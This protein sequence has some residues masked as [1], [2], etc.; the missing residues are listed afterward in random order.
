[1]GLDWHDSGVVLSSRPLGERDAVVTLLTREH[2][3]H[4]GLV[5]G[6]A[7]RRMTPVLQAGN[8]VAVA[9]RARLSDHL[10]SFTLELL[11]PR[12][13]AVLD[14]A[15]RLAALTAIC[16]LVEQCLPEREPH[17]RLFDGLAVVFDTIEAD[18]PW[19]PLM[20]RFEVELLAELGFGLDLANCAVTGSPDD[21]THVSPRTG[22]AVSAR[23]A[24]PYGDRLLRLPRFLLG[25]QA[26][27]DSLEEV[28]DGFALT[29]H[30]IERHILGP[31]GRGL[32]PARARLLN[33]L[34]G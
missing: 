24:E 4:P 16:A 3:R 31:Q 26:G 15:R 6:G 30:F 22:R 25:A 23:A 20:V 10:G 32:P 14:S 8:D 34:L 1:M 28:A 12:A 33:L 27:S 18:G 11:R 21:L 17:A 5:R 19:A 7:G 9:W 2:G 29:G 13:A